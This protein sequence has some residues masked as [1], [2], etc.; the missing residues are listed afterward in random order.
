MGKVP[1]GYYSC[2]HGFFEKKK[3]E[4]KRCI[5]E[6]VPLQLCYYD[7]LYI[8]KG[9]TLTFA[10]S[11]N[12]YDRLAWNWKRTLPLREKVVPLTD[13]LHRKNHHKFHFATGRLRIDQML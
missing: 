1:V 8:E 7:L 3:E 4:K 9:E 5:A 10:S 6:R 12:V 13:N 11:Q 2:K